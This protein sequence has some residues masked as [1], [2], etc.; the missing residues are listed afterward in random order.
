MKAYKLEVLIIDHDGI[1][2][3]EIRT[4]LE[5]Q[6]YPNHCMYPEVQSIDWREIGDWHDDH[7]LNR[8]KTRDSEYRRLF[9]A[10]S[11]TGAP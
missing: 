4:V 11:P 5:N 9:A 3:D 6:K 7:P 10:P 2:P 1:G 8:T